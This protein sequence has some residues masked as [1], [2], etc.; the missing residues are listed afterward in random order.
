MPTTLW[1]DE[2][3]IQKDRM[4]AL[5]ACGQFTSCYKLMDYILKLKKNKKIKLTEEELVAVDALYDALEKDWKQF[6]ENPL[7]HVESL[8]H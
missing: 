6:N 2:K 5:I 7:F 1:W 4:D 8:K 3:D